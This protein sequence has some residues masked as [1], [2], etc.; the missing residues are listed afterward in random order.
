MP[1]QTCKLCGEQPAKYVCQKCGRQVCEDCLNPTMWMCKE[2]FTQSSEAIISPRDSWLTPFKLFLIGFYT[3]SIGTILIM[4]SIL[5]SKA[6]LNMGSGIV[7][8]L[9]PFPP[10]I[11]GTWPHAIFIFVIAVILVVV[12][13]FLFTFKVRKKD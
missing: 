9:F 4:V 12:Y 8:W 1:A 11:V 5:L 6:T 13:L 7:I 10:L 3:I 2:C